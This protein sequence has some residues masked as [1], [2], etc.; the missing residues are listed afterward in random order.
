M[1]NDFP[2]HLLIPFNAP[3]NNLDLPTQTYGCRHTN[4]DICGSCYLD[5]VCAFSNNDNICYKPSKKWI[6]QYE[7]LKGQKN[8][9][10]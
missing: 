7:L 8:E 5:K 9:N 3:L 6:K 4:P 2:N 10:M 1:K